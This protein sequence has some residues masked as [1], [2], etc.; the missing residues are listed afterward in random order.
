MKRKKDEKADSIPLETPVI[1]VSRQSSVVLKAI[2]LHG[3]IE[4]PKSLT[5]VTCFD[6]SSL[7]AVLP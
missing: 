1:P 4:K 3:K 6:R 7:R 2:N 5:S